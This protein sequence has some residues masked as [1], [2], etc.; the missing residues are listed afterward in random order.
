MSIERKEMHVY[1][2]VVLLDKGRVVEM[3]TAARMMLPKLDS[4]ASCAAGL[5]ILP[6]LLHGLS[7]AQ[8][9]WR[10]LASLQCC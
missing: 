6:E 2:N 1:A 5:C 10:M 4:S 9:C 3:P 8:Y 7:T